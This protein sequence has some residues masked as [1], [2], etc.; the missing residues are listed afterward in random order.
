MTK[1]VSEKIQVL[2]AIAIVIV[3]YIHSGFHDYELVG[4][5]QNLMIQ[6]MISGMIGRCAVPLFYIISGYLFFLSANSLESVFDKMKKRINTLFIPFVASSVFFIAIFVIVDFVPG[7]EK[8]MNS[9]L[10]QL[11]K[12]DFLS[13]LRNIFYK[14]DGGVSPL[15]GQLWFLRDLMIMVVFA[16]IW[17]YLYKYLT[18][19]WIPIVFVLNYLDIPFFPIYPLFWFSLGGALKY[20]KIPQFAITKNRQ[21][22]VALTTVFLVLC[23]FQLFT[24]DHAEQWLY[25]K[26]PIILLGVMAIWF[27]YDVF[28]WPDFSLKQHNY[29]E[30]LCSF[31]FFIYL[32][33]QPTINIVRKLVVFVIGKT[34]FGYLISYLTSPI[35]FIVLAIP[36]GMFL[37][38]YFAKAYGIAVGGR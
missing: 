16:P 11:F 38:K 35:I 26:I 31:T 8:F 7:T 20:F 30:T 24:L 21:L 6:E 28:A 5:E 22:G 29:L 10:S 23:F 15:A 3:V 37:K 4:M 18:W 33:H 34:S 17:Y 2:S 36:V 27:L 25:F 19:K 14:V 32:F 12:K 9:N 1:Y 13:I